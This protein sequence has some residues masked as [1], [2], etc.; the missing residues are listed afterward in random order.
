MAAMSDQDA[1]QLRFKLEN[2]SVRGRNVPKPISAWTQVCIVF[3][4]YAKIS[5]VQH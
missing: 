2:M 4:M 3:E 1:A 5:T